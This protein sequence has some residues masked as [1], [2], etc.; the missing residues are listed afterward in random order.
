M[1]DRRFESPTAD[2]ARSPHRSLAIG[3]WSTLIIADLVLIARRSAG[4]SHFPVLGPLAAVST[5]VV[6]AVS[7]TAWSLF[8]SSQ[9]QGLGSAQRHVPAAISTSI[10]FLW[11]W[12][13]A[14]GATPWT[15]GVLVGVVL[16]QAG[17]ILAAE[18]ERFHSPVRSASA[19]PIDTIEK[20]SPIERIAA[21]INDHQP[22]IDGDSAMNVESPSASASPSMSILNPFEAPGDMGQDLEE[23]EPACDTD[24]NQ[25]LWLSRRQTDEGE[26]IEGWVRVQLEAGQRETTVHVSF[27][28]PLTGA[29]EL[30]TEDLD[31]AGLEIRI[32]AMFPFGARL[33]IRR[34]ESGKH[35]LTGRIGFVAHSTASDRAA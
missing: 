23:M 15:F 6:A 14:V 16:V 1:P 4:E 28:P 5:V 26:W 18:L 7:W 11:A 2:P 25:T 33:S 12:P 3:I 13:V 35:E 17:L 31:G 9:R 22:R 19:T 21:S 10:V 24:E 32:A 8:T 34:T 30:E 20:P 27:C 29:P